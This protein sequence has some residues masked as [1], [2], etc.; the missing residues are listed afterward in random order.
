MPND[1]TFTIIQDTREKKPVEFAAHGAVESVEIAKLDTGDYSV[2]GMESVLM[3][4]RKASVDEVFM[5]L[6]VQ[7]GRFEKEMER[8][9]PYKY[10]YLVIEAN[11]SQIYY[12]SSY[13]N[14]S[15]KFIVARLLAIQH[16]YGVI[17]IFVG[18]GQHVSTYIVQLMKIIRLAEQDAH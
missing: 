18:K 9:K 7:W 14:M 8:A 17:P 4:E 3:I 10:K 15:G 5:C 11:L 12:G 16:K 13:S 6:G 1:D 2:K